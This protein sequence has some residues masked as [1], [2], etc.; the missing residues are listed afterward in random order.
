MD[1]HFKINRHTTVCCNTPFPACCY[2]RI[3]DSLNCLCPCIIHYAIHPSISI[4]SQ[5]LYAFTKPMVYVAVM[6]TELSFCCTVN[7][8]TFP[9]FFTNL[10][11]KRFQICLVSM[12]VIPS[13]PAFIRTE[14]FCTF[15]GNRRYWHT[16]VS[17]KRRI[18]SIAFSYSSE[19]VIS[20]VGFY[21]VTG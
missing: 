14:Y 19:I 12:T 2:L 9:T 10:Q 4:Y 6:G 7:L 16:A 13:M 8:K 17:A 15:A 3:V 1:I 18:C 5:Q 21:T 11:V 20:A